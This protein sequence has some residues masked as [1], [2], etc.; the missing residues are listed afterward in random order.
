MAGAVN[1]AASINVNSSVVAI[2]GLVLFLWFIVLQS[3]GLGTILG[4]VANLKYIDCQP[5][6]KRYDENNHIGLGS[7]L[8][9]YPMIW[10]TF[11]TLTMELFGCNQIDKCPSELWF[12]SLAVRCANNP[13]L[14]IGLGE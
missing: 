2:L 7:I 3:F 14:F 11:A 10:L 5:I 12:A 13:L 6:V 4:L 1:V 9:A 8:L